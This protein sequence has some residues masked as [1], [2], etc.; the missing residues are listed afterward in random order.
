MWT[1][2]PQNSKSLN[3]LLHVLTFYWLSFIAEQKDLKVGGVT[4][5]L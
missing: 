5:F 2:N 1:N 3:K 4:Y